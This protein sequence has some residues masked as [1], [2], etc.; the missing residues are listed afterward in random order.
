MGV[1]HGMSNLGGGLL[2]ILASGTQTEKEAVRYTVAHYYLAF[3]LIQMLVLAILLGQ[4]RTLLA[5]S[6][7]MFV[8]GA[9]FVLIGNRIFRHTK[10]EA[11]NIALNVFIATYGIAVLF[12]L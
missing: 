12:K 2:A 3:S 11:Y 10:N 7:T 1:I 6:L 4:H 8:S 5:N 9:V